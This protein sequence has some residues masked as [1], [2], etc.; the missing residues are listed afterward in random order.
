MPPS[1]VS[2]RTSMPPP[3]SVAV[4]RLSPTTRP[5]TSN[6]SKIGAMLPSLVLKSTVAPVSCGIL[7]EMLPF[8]VSALTSSF[9]PGRASID[10]SRTGRIR[11]DRVRRR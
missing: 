11:P 7:I 2:A 3:L 9:A 5:V 6:P 4:T 1:S 10:A 8:S